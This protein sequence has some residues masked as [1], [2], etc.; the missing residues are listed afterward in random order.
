[1]AQTA[2]MMKLT[3]NICLQDVYEPALEGVYEEMRHCG[4]EGM[5]FTY[6]TSPTETLKGAKA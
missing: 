6:T 2:A 4:L 1:M 5:N 3:P